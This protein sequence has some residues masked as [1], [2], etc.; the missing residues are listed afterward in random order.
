MCILVTWQ[1][2]RSELESGGPYYQVNIG[3]VIAALQLKV[4]HS[5]AVERYGVA[6]GS[7]SDCFVGGFRIIIAFGICC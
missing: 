2:H 7:N 6:S 3:A 5:I 1:V 4:V